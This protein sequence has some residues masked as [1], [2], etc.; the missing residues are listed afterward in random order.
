LLECLS[1]TVV[2]FCRIEGCSP[3]EGVPIGAEAPEEVRSVQRYADEKDFCNNDEAVDW[4]VWLGGIKA[5]IWV[6]LGEMGRQEGDK[7]L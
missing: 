3:G 4:D 2:P 7:L 5:R 1:G 6:I